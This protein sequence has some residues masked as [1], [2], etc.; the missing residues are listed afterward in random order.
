MLALE[1]LQSCPAQ[2]DALLAALG[3]MDSSSL[4]V[5]FNLSDV[6]I[7]LPYHVA[8]SIDGIHGGKTIGR[9]VV[10]EGDSTCVMSLSCW[11]AL[12]SLELVPSNTL[13]SAFDERSFRPHGILPDFEIKLAGKAVSVEVEVI[14]APLDY[15]LVLGRSWTYSMF[16]IASVVFQVVVFPHEGKLVAVDQLDFTRKGRMESNDSAVPLLIRSNLLHRSWGLEYT[17][18]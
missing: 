1:M 5:K 15:N 13:L 4:M 18:H 10:D 2:W 8:L 6:K 7:C 14:D 3:S 11:K 17:H 9:E 12:R 16:A